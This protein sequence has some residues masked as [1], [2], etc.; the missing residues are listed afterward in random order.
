MFV[1]AE[2]ALRSPRLEYRAY[3][4]RLVQENCALAAAMHNLT[5]ST[6]SR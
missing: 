3:Q 5:F 6:S 4:E 1:I 2:G